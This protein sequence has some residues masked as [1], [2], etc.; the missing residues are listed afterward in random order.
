MG[1]AWGAPK[2]KKLYLFLSLVNEQKNRPHDH[3]NLLWNNSLSAF[4][5][6]MTSCSQA[7]FISHPVS[8]QTPWLHTSCSLADK[9]L[10][11]TSCSLP[12][13]RLHTSCSLAN[14]RL[15]FTSCSLADT[16]L[17][18]TKSR[19][20]LSNVL[21]RVNLLLVYSCHLDGLCACFLIFSVMLPY[22]GHAHASILTPP[23][24]QCTSCTCQYL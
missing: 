2:I 23:W 8:R 17:H 18:F 11:F 12:Y 15:H 14:K 22:H 24:P 16:R 4:Y 13:T 19:L 6:C 10:H 9:R 3:I 1:E 5:P 21:I 20:T 7:D